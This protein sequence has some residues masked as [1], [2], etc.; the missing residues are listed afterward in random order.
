MNKECNMQLAH[1]Y[2]PCQ[3]WPSEIYDLEQSLIVGTIFPCLNQPK[4]EYEWSGINDQ[5]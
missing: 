3:V 4:S 5:K 1:A 2:V